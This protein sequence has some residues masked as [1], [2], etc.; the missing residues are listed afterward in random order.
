MATRDLVSLVFTANDKQVQD[1]LTRTDKG[2][3][4]VT[5]TAEKSGNRIQQ[6]FSRAG[7]GIKGAAGQIPGVGGALSALVSPAGL[8]TAGIGLVVGGLTKAVTGALDLGRELG[9]LRE[10]TGISAEGVADNAPGD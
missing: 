10:K 3:T 7:A 5:G 6:S 1:A 2:L 9:E 8:A 4:G